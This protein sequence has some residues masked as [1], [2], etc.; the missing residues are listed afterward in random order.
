M[1]LEA[2]IDVWTTVLFN[3]YLAGP[4]DR[5]LTWIGHPPE[6]PAHPWEN[7]LTMELLVVAIMIVVFWI[8]RLRL[9]VE[10]PG[11]MQHVAEML[12]RFF[13]D[14]TNETMGHGGEKYVS[15]FGT[16]FIFIL[17]LN[18][19]G[20]LPGFESPTMTP[21]VPAGFA[22]SVFVYYNY[23]GIR[24][25]G[26]FRYFSHFA[27]PYPLLAPLMIPLEIMSHLARMLSLTVRL[28]ANI[29]AGDKVIL[30]F[31]SLTYVVIPALF[32]GLHVFV[33]LLQAYI[34]MALTILYVGAAVAHEHD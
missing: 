34:F 6:N 8:L 5:L 23:M 30:V 24:E 12:Y 20:S 28:Y 10:R 18:L 22:V 32:Q 13:V 2:E 9:S 25:H 15:F 29:F 26:V 14:T 11:T 21:A 19:I 7:W 17:F 4:A 3:K 33:S 1:A 16:I 31:L 27:G